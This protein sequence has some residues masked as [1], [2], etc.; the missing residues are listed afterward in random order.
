MSIQQDARE[1]LVRNSLRQ[2]AFAALVGVNQSALSK[3]LNREGGSIAERIAPYIYERIP[4]PTT[5][6]PTT[7]PGSE[8]GAGEPETAQE[9]RD[10]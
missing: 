3:F 9:G 5:A 4:L 10:A 2:G 7:P 6:T 1:F 8:G